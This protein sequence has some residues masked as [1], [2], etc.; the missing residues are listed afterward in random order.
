VQR[1]KQRD[2]VDGFSHDPLVRVQAVTGAPVNRCS[3]CRLQ[4]VDWRK[5]HPDGNF[6]A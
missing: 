5:P 1:L 2:K 4:F 6:D 3:P